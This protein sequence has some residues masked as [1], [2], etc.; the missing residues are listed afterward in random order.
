MKR[1]YTKIPFLLLL[2]L[3][4]MNGCEKQEMMMSKEKVTKQLCH[5]WTRLFAST[6]AEV[7]WQFSEG[8]VYI[9]H[10]DH[11]ISQGNYSIDCSVTKVKVNMSGFDSG[12]NFL[13]LTW[14]VLTLNDDAL[15][16]TDLDKGTQQYEFVR[17][18]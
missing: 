18:D 17:K 7:T 13:N 10:N 1:I 6:E 15:V 4:F 12:H 2:V 11:V 8:K 3:P 9:L 16:I 5:T 14:Q